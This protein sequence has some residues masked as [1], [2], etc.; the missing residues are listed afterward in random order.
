MQT[1]RVI[2]RSLSEVE[3]ERSPS[4]CLSRH[5]LFLQ[6]SSLEFDSVICLGSYLDMD[7]WRP[8][9]G[10]LPLGARLLYIIHTLY[11]DF[12]KSSLD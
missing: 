10:S 8:I 2:L 6:N 9:G 4:L 11:L 3:K 5:F 1:L 7:I 12:D